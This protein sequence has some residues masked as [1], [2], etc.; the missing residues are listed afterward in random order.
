MSIVAHPARCVCHSFRNVLWIDQLFYGVAGCLTL[1]TAERLQTVF[2]MLRVG[3]DI[4]GGC[5]VVSDV[6]GRGRRAILALHFLKIGNIVHQWIDC[7]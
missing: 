6:L 1:L 3:L 7:S 5:I 2:V 4:T